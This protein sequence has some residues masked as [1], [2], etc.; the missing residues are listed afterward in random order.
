MWRRRPAR[1]ICKIPK[2]LV[3]VCRDV[4]GRLRDEVRSDGKRSS[5]DHPV[6]QPPHLLHRRHTKLLWPDPRDNRPLPQGQ[7]P[8]VPGGLPWAFYTQT[9][10]QVTF[11][12]APHCWLR[13]P[14]LCRTQP[15]SLKFIFCNGLALHRNQARATFGDWLNGI[16]EL[17]RNLHAM[18]LDVSSFSCLAALT[19]VN[20]EQA[21]VRFCLAQCRAWN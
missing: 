14:I 11:Y 9:C 4:G 12:P 18:E 2:C 20:G 13:T 5:E 10:L 8:V 16:I 17:S 6:L 7:G 1:K 3:L 15:D 21:M 19:L